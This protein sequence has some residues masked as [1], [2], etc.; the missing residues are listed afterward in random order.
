MPGTKILKPN[1]LAYEQRF[2]QHGNLKP[3]S[4]LYVDS[5]DGDDGN[6]QIADTSSSIIWPWYGGSSTD[7]HP[8]RAFTLGKS[9]Q[10]WGHMEL[11]MHIP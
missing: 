2:A 9:F 11:R 10:S 1:E 8:T 6:L 7:L 3:E 4:I 5:T